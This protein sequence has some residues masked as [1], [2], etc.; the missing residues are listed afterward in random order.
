MMINKAEE[1]K[2][3]N[4]ELE[5]RHLRE[6]GNGSVLSEGHE[7]E[8]CVLFSPKLSEQSAYAASGERIH[9]QHRAASINL[10]S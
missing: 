5:R 8:R 7:T 6:A 9:L 4:P 10:Q 2:W 1:S 3:M